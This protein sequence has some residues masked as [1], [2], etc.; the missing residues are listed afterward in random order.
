M[1]IRGGKESQ[2]ILQG[3]LTQAWLGLIWGHDR[4]A[5]MISKK[6]VPLQNDP[7]DRAGPHSLS[8]GA[9]RGIR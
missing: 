9:L 7:G 1:T 2:Q 6:P 4:G 5:L 8:P 3:V